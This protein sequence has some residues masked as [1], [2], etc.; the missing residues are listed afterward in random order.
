MTKPL[1][2]L[3][4]GVANRGRWPLE[5]CKPE[6]GFVSAGLVDVQPQALAEARKLTG[7]PESACFASLEQALAGVEVDC[8]IACVPTRFH[9]ALAKQAIAAGKPVLIEKGMAP[10][11]ASAQDLARTVAGTPGARAAVAQNYRYNGSERS[12]RRAVTD[13]S[14]DGHVGRAHFIEYSQYRVRPSVGTLSYPFASVWDMS[15]HHFDT[16]MFLFGPIEAMTA[17]GW[18]AH[19]SAY[20]HDNNTTAHIVF[21]SGVVAHYAHLHDAAR[22]VLDIQIHGEAGC[23]VLGRDGLVFSARPLEQFG[24]RPETVI[25]YEPSRG[26]TDLLVDFHAYITAG[27]EPGISVRNNLETMAA[28][29]MMVR[30]IREGRT[31]R[32]QELGE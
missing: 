29:E 11:W 31:V 22:N 18:K 27:I 5:R 17:H 25:P 10:D 3:H 26:E 21:R 20:E 24:T 1:R 7:L 14:Y 15:C 12:L 2:V 19:W 13:P 9:V 16:L 8:V 4:V 6:I 23:A 28:C 32:R 30:S